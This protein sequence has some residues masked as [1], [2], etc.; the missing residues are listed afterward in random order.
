MRLGERDERLM[1]MVVRR[2]MKEEEFRWEGLGVDKRKEQE[3]CD[4]SGVASSAGQGGSTMRERC[5]ASSCWGIGEGDNS[6]G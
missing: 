3:T 5:D 1:E 6:G 2:M 4:S